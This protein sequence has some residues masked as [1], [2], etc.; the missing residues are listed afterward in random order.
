VLEPSQDEVLDMRYAI[1]FTPPPGDPLTLAAAGWLGRN[2]YSGHAADHPGLRG[3]GVHEIAFHTALPRRFGFHA[4]FKAPFRLSEG[5]SEA[6]LLRE[7]MHFAGSMEPVSL[8]GLSVGRIGEVYGLILDRPCAAVDHL[9]ASVV[10][11]FDGYR[12]PLSEAEIERRNPDRLSAPQFSNLNR[13]GHPYVMDE[14]RFHMTLTGPL[15]ARDFPRI[16]QALKAHFDPVLAESV[17]VG[18]L[19]LFVENEQGAPFQVHS[20]HPLGRVSSRKIA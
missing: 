15:L 13:W 18:N 14:F 17:T 1:C 8:S 3:L 2:V 7:L 20:L 4:T 11:A 19:A 5:V 12:A 6:M 16:E 9:A 10:Q